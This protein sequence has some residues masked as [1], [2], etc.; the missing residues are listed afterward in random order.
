MHNLKSQSQGPYIPYHYF[1]QSLP[2]RL[3]PR[4]IRG[5]AQGGL[6]R[7]R[8]PDHR[9]GPAAGLLPRR[10]LVATAPLAAEPERNLLRPM[11]HDRA[12]GQI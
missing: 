8:G 11:T 10:S 5:P 3:R 12:R 4:R 2:A 7:L 1:P 6:R 9:R